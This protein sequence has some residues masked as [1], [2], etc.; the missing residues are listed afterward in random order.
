[1]SRLIVQLGCT[2]TCTALVLWKLHKI[3]E[4]ER[5]MIAGR[6]AVAD[7]DA[8]HLSIVN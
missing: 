1:M 4:H 7:A 8:R 3:S 2:I 5:A 6:Q